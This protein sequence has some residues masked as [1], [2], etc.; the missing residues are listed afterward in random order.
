MTLYN[1]YRR[2][3]ENC[4]YFGQV[5]KIKCLC[6]VWMDGT[7]QH[8]RRHRHT[9][10]TRDWNTALQRIAQIEQGTPAPQAIRHGA[11]VP[12][13]EAIQ[14]YLTDCRARNLAPNSL[15]AYTNTLKHLRAHFD[16]RSLSDVTLE[17]LTKYRTHRA[18]VAARS[19]R[20]EITELRT[21]FRF[22]VDREWIDKNPASRLVLPKDESLP[23]LPFTEDE[24]T[25]ML[26]VCDEIVDT[27]SAA[28]QQRSRER[29]RA[30]L[31][32][33]LYSGM[34]ISDVILLKRDKVNM[35]TGQILIR[36]MKTGAPLY[37]PIP[38]VAIDALRVLPEESPVYFFWA[39]PE[40]CKF[41]SAVAAASRTIRRVLKRAKVTDGHPHRFRDTFAVELLKN[42]VP[43][44]TVQLLLGHT[45]IKTTEKHYAPYVASMQRLLDEAVATLHFGQPSPRRVRKPRVNAKK[46]TLRN[47]QRDTPGRIL[48]FPLP[49]TA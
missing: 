43:L 42:G 38:R 3:S 34:R 24:V 28:H 49:Q 12:L 25:A 44:H 18:L 2:H 4:R 22:C 6:P 9:L 1:P 31:L 37:I 5:G 35:Q 10:K 8:G 17:A 27:R 26:A 23:T 30:L 47:T 48:A 41:Y 39:G 21:F 36:M 45:S 29:A 19:S 20:G 15:E 14:T 32:I 16:G 33:L 40:G 46:N 11:G 13:A 7:D